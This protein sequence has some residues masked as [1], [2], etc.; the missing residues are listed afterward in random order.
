MTLA[1]M[2]Q[3]VS[4]INLTLLNKQS[5]IS[6]EWENV[7]NLFEKSIWSLPGGIVLYHHR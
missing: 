3:I 6:H 1:S 7:M 5:H 4:Q 2:D